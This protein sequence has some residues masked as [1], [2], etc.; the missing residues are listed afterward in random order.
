MIGFT[1]IKNSKRTDHLQTPLFP[2]IRQISHELIV[3]SREHFKEVIDFDEL[4]FNKM[5][6]NPIRIS[7]FSG[8]SFG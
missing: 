4:Y 6:Q 7:G 8:M 3:S 1:W 5:N 2:S